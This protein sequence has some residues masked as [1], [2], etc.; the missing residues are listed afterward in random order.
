MALLNTTI[1]KVSIIYP[2]C[3][4]MPMSWHFINTKRMCVFPAGIGIC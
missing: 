3:I 1:Y 2:C 4:S